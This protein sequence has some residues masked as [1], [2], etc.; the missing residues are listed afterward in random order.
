MSESAT[1]AVMKDWVL[2]NYYRVKKKF[3]YET[4]CSSTL[5]LKGSKSPL[6]GDADST[7]FTFVTLYLKSKNKTIKMKRKD[8]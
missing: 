3:T 7:S 5:T 8:F 4:G 2:V 1:I 6:R